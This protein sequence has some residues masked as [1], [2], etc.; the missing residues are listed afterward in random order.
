LFKVDYNNVV[1]VNFYKNDENNIPPLGKYELFTK[2][3]YFFI[4]NET[5][6]KS[7]NIE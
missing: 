2:I 3:H 6:K 7:I 5:Y 4:E 1:F